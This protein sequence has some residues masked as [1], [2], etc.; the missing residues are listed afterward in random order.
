MCL[1]QLV[2]SYAID[3]NWDIIHVTF[4]SYDVRRKEGGKQQLMSN[5]NFT[6]QTKLYIFHVAKIANLQKFYVVN[7][8]GFTVVKEK[9]KVIF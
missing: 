3:C 4:Q 2:I 5:Q 9:I 6:V 7:V 8:Y 1:Y